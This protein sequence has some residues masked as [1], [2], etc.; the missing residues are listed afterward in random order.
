MWVGHPYMPDVRGCRGGPVLVL[1]DA[2]GAAATKVAWPLAASSG[3]AAPTDADVRA[4]AGGRAIIID[5]PAARSTIRGALV[6]SGLRARGAPGSIPR[7]AA[8]DL[9]VRFPPGMTAARVFALVTDAVRAAR[10]PGV[11]VNVLRGQSIEGT[12]LDHAPAILEALDT[13]CLAGF[14]VRPV[15]RIRGFDPGGRPAGRTVG[16]R[17]GVARTRSGR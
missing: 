8:A 16:G 13:A 3:R 2:L 7:R 6:V 1:G 17:A 14:G 12:S 5:H 11:T 10:P 4:A 9:D 15:R